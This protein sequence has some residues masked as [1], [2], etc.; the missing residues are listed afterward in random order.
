[1]S[2]LKVQVKLKRLR[3]ERTKGHDG[4]EK[5]YSEKSL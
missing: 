1:M 3:Q 2:R 4:F 5:V